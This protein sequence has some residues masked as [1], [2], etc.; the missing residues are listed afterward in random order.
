MGHSAEIRTQKHH[1]PIGCF[2]E[3][4]FE[5]DIIEVP[6]PHRHCLE[7]SGGR[8]FLSFVGEWLSLVE[9]LVRDTVEIH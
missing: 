6:G 3:S 8:C 7:C 4:A 5:W 2:R 9:H 1:Y